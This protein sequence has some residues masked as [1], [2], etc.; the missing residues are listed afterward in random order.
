V[1]AHNTAW[2]AERLS[3]W[4][5]VNWAKS[6]G[7]VIAALDFSGAAGDI[8]LTAREPSPDSWRQWDEALWF[9]LAVNTAEGAL[10]S[11]GCAKSATRRIATLITGDDEVD[12]ETANETHVELLSQVA[13]AISSVATEK[14][15]RSVQFS[16]A[17]ASSQPP[18]TGLG[19]EYIFTI[20]DAEQVLVL[21]PNDPL[22]ES[23]SPPEMQQPEV[24][25]A[26]PAASAASAGAGGAGSVPAST[27]G[28]NSSAGSNGEDNRLLA[29]G[30]SA[31]NNLAMLLEV[32]MELSVSFG[33]TE[34][35]LQEILKLASG[36]IVELNRSVTD[37][38]DVM[39]N[40]RVIA[41]GEVVVVD[42]NYGVR[43]TEIVSRQE[44]IRSIF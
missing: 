29:L 27:A 1:G 28:G 23:L 31:Q 34:M 24:A 33:R 20:G 22:V 5:V 40:N 3:H 4:L 39:V 35:P 16:A 19:V 42:G 7:D 17:A 32:E 13:S 36:S 21:V 10:I 2:K 6:F 18:E 12:D 37:P 41:R 14:L 9:D 25:E 15:G 26:T 43:V 44:R 8:Q 38:V 30:A 11:V